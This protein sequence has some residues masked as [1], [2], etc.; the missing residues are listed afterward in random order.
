MKLL[1][2]FS[3]HVPIMVVSQLQ[4]CFGRAQSLSVLKRVIEKYNTT[5]YG[6]F[7]CRCAVHEFLLCLREKKFRQTGSFL[8]PPP[9]AFFVEKSVNILQLERLKTAPKTLHNFTVAVW[10][11]QI[12]TLFT[13]FFPMKSLIFD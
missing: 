10:G 1:S 4:I 8:S 9:M 2:S 3:F 7:M 13:L 6:K 12:Q 5:R 11:I